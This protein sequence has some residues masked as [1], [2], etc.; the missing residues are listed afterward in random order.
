MHHSTLA[1]RMQPL[2]AIPARLISDKAVLNQDGIP[3]CKSWRQHPSPLLPETSNK[4]IRDR[5]VWSYIHLICGLVVRGPGY[6]TEMYCVSCEVRTEC[7]CYVEE[8]IPPLWS[9]GRSSLIQIQRS[10]FDSRNYQIFWVV[11]GLEQGPLS[12]VSTTEELLER[13]SSGSSLE[14]REYGSRD[15]LCWP[16]NTPYP[17][18]LAIISVTG[19]GRSVGIVHV[20]THAMEFV[21]WVECGLWEK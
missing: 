9:S 15:A 6:R 11:V 16:R 2:P 20:Q 7:I 14:S 5:D 18:M 3:H 1:F 13:N 4:R 17:Q 21:L 10:G 19:G 12:L 8:S